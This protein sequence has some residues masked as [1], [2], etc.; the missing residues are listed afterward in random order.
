ML[1]LRRAVAW[2]VLAGL[3][4]AVPLRPGHTQSA[5]NTPTVSVAKPIERRIV[6]WDEYWGRFEAVASVEVR[7]RVSGFI[8][9][10][11]Y[12]DGQLVKAGDL[13]YTIDQRPF[14][15]A[16]ESAE[17]EVTRG[18][19]QVDL[20]ENE[21][22]RARPLLKS[23]AVT[24]RDFDQRRANL[25]VVKAQLLSAE[26]ALKNAK[27]NL[28]WTEVRAPIAGRISDSKADV[29]T[30]VTGG[31]SGATLLTTIVSLAPIHFVFD[32]AEADFL[33]YM[34]KSTNGERQSSREKDNPVKV[35]LADEDDFRHEGRMDFVDNQ[36]NP[37]S[38]TIRGRAIFDNKD[39][40]LTPGLF[41]RLKLFG[42]EMDA[43]LIPDT[44]VISDQMRKIVYTVGE[45]GLVKAA[46]VVLG[47]M[48]AGLRVVKSGLSPTDH[49]VIEGL[50]NPFVRPGAKVNA[51]PGEIKAA[52]AAN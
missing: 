30:L 12:K 21:V 16:V 23:A 20:A 39:Q 52:A 19:A 26:A 22:E 5:Q 38:G 7:P 41:G 44:A 31:V 40:L 48:E 1:S 18:K 13:L 42:G 46:P 4:L 51:Q 37:R 50:A 32:A 28:E 2:G 9:A 11:H 27:L 15:I 8:D 36:L 49:V 47:P 10:I 14:R 35:K 29:G 43:L 3:A 6:T 25:S 33:R 45:D 24:E 17:A 34:R